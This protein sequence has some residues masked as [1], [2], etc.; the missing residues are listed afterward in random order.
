MFRMNLASNRRRVALT[1]QRLILDL[2][3]TKIYYVCGFMSAKK[4]IGSIQVSDDMKGKTIRQRVVVPATPNE[5]YEAFIDP[6][7]HSKF[8]GSR[9]TFDPE[10]GGVYSMGWLHIRKKLS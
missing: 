1:I 3:A 2:E 8:T 9:G 10:I 6:K 5:V 7:K 4:P